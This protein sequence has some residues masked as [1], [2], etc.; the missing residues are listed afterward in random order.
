MAGF[1]R[2]STF[3]SMFQNGSN[4]V[5]SLLSTIPSYSELP[6]IFNFQKDRLLITYIIGMEHEEFTQPHKKATLGLSMRL[7]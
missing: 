4:L 7:S 3:L 1:L 5:E 6:G 2:A